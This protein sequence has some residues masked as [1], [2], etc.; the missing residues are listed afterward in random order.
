VH[1]EQ[2]PQT[3]VAT[4]ALLLLNAP[5]VAQQAMAFA[6]RRPAG[7]ADDAAVAWLWRQ[8]LCRAPSAGELAAA[9][10]WLADVRRDADEAAA[11]SG[12][13]QALLA[14]NEFVY[15]D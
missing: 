3:A 6:A 14:A 10:R 13:A 2:R 11:W 12:L 1:I 4:Q 8:A 5:L 7:L 9:R 15:V